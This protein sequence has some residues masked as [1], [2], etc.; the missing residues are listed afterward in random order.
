M[1]RS[2]ERRKIE[3]TN[4][5]LI[6][7]ASCIEEVEEQDNNKNQFIL[8]LIPSIITVDT[9]TVMIVCLDDSTSNDPIYVNVL[10]KKEQ[11][12]DY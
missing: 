11:T 5:D 2:Q 6:L 7:Q 9:A 3:R 12:L 8:S 1:T 4:F 10:K